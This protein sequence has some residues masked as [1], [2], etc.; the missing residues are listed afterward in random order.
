ML[1]AGLSLEVFKK[2]A[3]N[4]LNMCIL[5][6]YCVVGTV[7]NKLVQ[8][9]A[10][11]T[12]SAA[13]CALLTRVQKV[14]IDRNTTIDV[15]CSIR[16]LSF[17]AHADA[18]GIMQLIQQV[19]PR[20]V[21][22]VHGEKEKMQFL[23]Q[24]IIDKFGVNCYDPANG[25]SVTIPGNDSIPVSVFA[26]LLK[27]ESRAQIAHEA[28]KHKPLDEI[29]LSGVALMKGNHVHIMP[30]EEAVEEIGLASHQLT[31]THRFTVSNKN[32]DAVG[33]IHAALSK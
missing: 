9:Q 14:E 15:N 11:K 25:T 21:M 5:P 24:K 22:L 32:V 7:G 8:G 29:A 19:Q 31:F 33:L 10:P 6:G 28:K 27:R 4:P 20:N 17:S 16:S 1:H 18:K 13:S 2:W 3:P 30:I 12:V 26:S 23:K